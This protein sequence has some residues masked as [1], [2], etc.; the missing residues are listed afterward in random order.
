[1]ITLYHSPH[2]FKYYEH[3]FFRW[4]TFRNIY[5]LSTDIVF[6]TLIDPE[7]VAWYD[8]LAIFW[9]V[10]YLLE[11]F[12]TIHRLYRFGGTGD[13]KRIFKRFVLLL[14]GC[15]LKTRKVSHRP[16]G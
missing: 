10:S 2:K 6:L 4:C 9:I 15:A 1:M 11:N 7:D 12:R 3:N 8:I 14:R 5:V 13:S 16:R